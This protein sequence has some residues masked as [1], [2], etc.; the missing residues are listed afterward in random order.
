[1]LELLG[2]GGK[3]IVPFLLEVPISLWALKTFHGFSSNVI[4]L[5]I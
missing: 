4:R 3:V 1:M 5:Y 2:N